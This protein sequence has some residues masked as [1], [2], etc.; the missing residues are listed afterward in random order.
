MGLTSVW[1]QLGLWLAIY[2]RITVAGAHKSF[3]STKQ[4]GVGLR[5]VCDSGIC[6]TTPGV[7]QVSGYVDIEPNMHLVGRH[8]HS[9]LMINL[10]RTVVLVL[11]STE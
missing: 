1:L 7:R 2:F 5:Y 8:L 3:Q 10:V 4:A 11:R 9:D 6:E